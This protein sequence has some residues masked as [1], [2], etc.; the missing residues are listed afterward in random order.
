MART[1]VENLRKEGWLRRLDQVGRRLFRS[2]APATLGDPDRILVVELWHI[3]DVVL[4]TAALPALRRR[5]PRAKLFL[6]AKPHARTILDGSGLV[7][8]FIPFDFPWTA[9][10]GKYRVWRYHPVKLFRL[11]RQLRSAEFD[12]SIDCRMDPRS[13]LV[14]Y[15]SGA[16]R[17]IGYD[18]GGGSFWLTDTVPARPDEGHKVDDWVALLAPLGITGGER[19]PALSVSEEER[20]AAEGELRAL[21]LLGK[22]L[23]AIHPGARE[24]VRRWDLR[25]F[26]AVAAHVLATGVADVLVVLDDEGYGRMSDATNVRY[27]SGTLEEIKAI[28]SLADLVISNDSGPMHIAAAVG[29]PVVAIFGPQRKEWYGPY[30]SGHSVVSL[31]IMPCRPCFDNCIFPE[32]VCLTGLGAEAVIAKV[33]AHFANLDLEQV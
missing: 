23:V 28:L 5:F 30:G 10:S 9:F 1:R 4:A 25:K 6:L 17:R 12:V 3:G 21:G 13:N 7:D 22:P 31:E 14:A 24:K 27:I 33:D 20:T 16:K 32:P 2:R 11:F 18:F 15:L 19:A 8:E 29:T 26:E